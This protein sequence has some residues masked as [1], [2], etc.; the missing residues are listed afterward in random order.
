MLIKCVHIRSATTQR[1]AEVLSGVPLG[2][3]I[4]TALEGVE[5]V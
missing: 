4:T 2:A 3:I 1:A 5:S